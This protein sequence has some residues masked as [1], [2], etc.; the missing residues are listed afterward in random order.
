MI[1]LEIKTNIL[2]GYMTFI[3][4][5]KTYYREIIIVVLIGIVVALH[6]NVEIVKAEKATLEQTINT[7]NEELKAETIKLNVSNATIEQLQANID[8]QNKDF[9][10]LKKKQEN[11]QKILS[12][13]LS[14]SKEEVKTAN[15]KI[16]EMIEDTSEQTGDECLDIKNELNKVGE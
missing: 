8:K 12:D 3:E 13:Q 10:D 11:N 5:L 14:K 16:Q 1:V 2:G 4:L 9:Q 7:V 6:L 15:K